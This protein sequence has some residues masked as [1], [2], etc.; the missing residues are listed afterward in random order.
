LISVTNHS[1]KAPKHPMI[2]FYHRLGFLTKGEY[3]LVFV[4]QCG[5]RLIF[6]CK[7]L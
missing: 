1:K 7:V 3:W 2:R 6:W 5:A 4:R